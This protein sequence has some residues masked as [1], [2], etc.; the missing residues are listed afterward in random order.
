[1]IFT[2]ELKIHNSHVSDIIQI[3]AGVKDGRILSY[4][5]ICLFVSLDNFSLIWRRHHDL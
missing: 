2:L 3:D 1:M 4:T 5:F